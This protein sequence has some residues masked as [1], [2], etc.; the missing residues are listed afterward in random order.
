MTVNMN[1]RPL[2]QVAD[3]IAE[4]F[5]AG[6]ARGELLVQQCSACGHRQ[7]YPRWCCTQ[8]AG[9]VGWIVGSGRGTVH[10]YTVIRQNHAEPYRSELPY[11]VAMIDLEEG[12]RMMS[13]VTDIDPDTVT[14]GMPVEVH[15]AA[16]D[17]GD[18]HLPF[19]RPVD[20]SRS[21]R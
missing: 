11:V 9:A 2:P 21:P 13:N 10:T 1:R 18:V 8:C 14:I 15:F 19:F 17:D 5:F 12:P 6:C 3:P 4:E 7:F 20:A 16:S